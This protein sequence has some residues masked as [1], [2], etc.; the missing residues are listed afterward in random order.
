MMRP[1]ITSCPPPAESGRFARVIASDLVA[2]FQAPDSPFAGSEHRA[3]EFASHG[4]SL[5]RARYGDDDA[6]ERYYADCIGSAFESLTLKAPPLATLRTSATP[7]AVRHPPDEQIAIVF[8]P[9]KG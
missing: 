4:L 3:R 2:Y 1:S 7:F 8:G 5:L 6:L 9:S